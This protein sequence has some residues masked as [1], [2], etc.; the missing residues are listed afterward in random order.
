MIFPCK[1]FTDSTLHESGQRGQDVDRRVDLSVVELTI[2]K[3]LS[4]GLI[5]KYT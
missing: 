1:L 4:L 3:D 5:V 2:N